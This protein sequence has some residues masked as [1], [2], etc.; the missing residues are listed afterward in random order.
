M[1]FLLIRADALSYFKLTFQ[2]IGTGQGFD[3][4]MNLQACQTA[5]IISADEY[6]IHNAA[7][8]N[9]LGAVRRFVAEEVFRYIESQ[10]EINGAAMG[11]IEVLFTTSHNDGYNQNREKPVPLGTASE[12]YSRTNHENQLNTIINTMPFDHINTGTDPDPHVPD[13]QIWVD[14]GLPFECHHL[15]QS[16]PSWG[17]D[18]YSLILHEA[19]HALGFSSLFLETGF[20]GLA[21]NN[22]VNGPYGPYSTF[23]IFLRDGDNLPLIINGTFTGNFSPFITDSITFALPNFPGRPP[24]PIFSP[25]PTFINGS[26]LCHLDLRRSNYMQP[27]VMAPQISEG[28]S[29]RKWTLDELYI[30]C[31][32]GYTL[33]SNVALQK[34]G[35]APGP[36]GINDA[37]NYTINNT[38]REQCFD[39]VANDLPTGNIE[40]SL[41]YGTNGLLNHAPYKCT[42]RVESGNQRI[43][44][45]YKPNWCGQALIQYQP[46]D[47]L[48]RRPGNVVRV[49]INGPNCNFCPDD[50]CNLVCNGDFE[51]AVPM[52]IYEELPIRK[53]LDFPFPEPSRV[54]FWWGNHDELFMRGSKKA[55]GFKDLDN[56]HNP[57]AWNSPSVINN[58]YVGMYSQN[59]SSSVGENIYTRTVIPIQVNT[60]YRL[61]FQA[62]P[63]DSTIIDVFVS[64]APPGT[65]NVT[66]FLVQS[67][68]LMNP[69]EINAWNLLSTNT[70]RIT[71]PPATTLPWQFLIFQAR[72]QTAPYIYI[73]DIRLENVDFG[74]TLSKTAD[75]TTANPGDIVTFTIT[76]TNTGNR[77]VR[78]VI[79]SDLVDPSVF[80]IINIFHTGTLN[81]VNPHVVEYS[82][83]PTTGQFSIRT[84]IITAEV[85]PLASCRT[86]SNCAQITQ[87]RGRFAS[88]GAWIDILPFSCPKTSDCR[89]I[90]IGNG[91]GCPCENE[92]ANLGSKDIY[93]CEEP[94]GTLQL[95]PPS[96]FTSPYTNGI[97]SYIWVDP[98]NVSTPSNNL[99]LPSP[100]I[101][102]TYTLKILSTGGIGPNCQVAFKNYNV[103]II[104]NIDPSIVN[105]NLGCEGYSLNSLPL[106]SDLTNGNIIVWHDIN[107]NVITDP[108]Y[109]LQNF[110]QITGSIMDSQGCVLQSVVYNIRIDCCIIDANF[111]SFSKLIG[112]DDLGD[113]TTTTSIL[114][115]DGGTLHCASGIYYAHFI[116][117]N[118]Q[119]NLEWEKRYDENY[120]EEEIRIRVIKLAEHNGEYYFIGNFLAGDRNRNH[121]DFGA[122]IGKLDNSGNIQWVTGIKSVEGRS[123]VLHTNVLGQIDGLMVLG[124]HNRGNGPE[125]CLFKCNFSGTVSWRRYLRTNTLPGMSSQINT[126]NPARDIVEIFTNQGAAD[127][128]IVVGEY[129]QSVPQGNTPVRGMVVTKFDNGGNYVSHKIFE[130]EEIPKKI[131]QTQGTNPGDR[132]VLIVGSFGDNLLNEYPGR[133][134]FL[135][136]LDINLNPLWSNNYALVGTSQNLY[137]GLEVIEQRE[138][139]TN[140]LI[141]YLMLCRN[142]INALTLVNTNVDGTVKSNGINRDY[143]FFGASIALNGFLHQYAPV[144]SFGNLGITSEGGYYLAA[145]IHKNGPRGIIVIKTNNRGTASCQLPLKIK[146]IPYTTN[147]YLAG[148]IQ[149]VPTYDAVNR[150]WDPMTSDPIFGYCCKKDL[151]YT[152][153]TICENMNVNPGF[154]F[155][156]CY[157]NT[158]F[159]TNAHIPGAVFEWNFGDGTPNSFVENPNHQYNLNGGYT[160]TVC[161]TVTYLGCTDTK[162]QT[163]TID[164]DESSYIEE[165]CP[166]DGV[167]WFWVDA[168]KYDPNNSYDHYIIH[169]ENGIEADFNSQISGHQNIQRSTGDYTIRYYDPN[170]CLKKILHLRIQPKVPSQTTCFKTVYQCLFVLD[171][172]GIMPDC[173]DC[174]PSINVGDNIELFPVQFLSSIN[175]VSKY[176]RRIIN[177]T[178]CRECIFT[179]DIVRESCNFEP[180]FTWYP[181]PP[182]KWIL[183][184][185]T[186]TGPQTQP[187]NN[188]VSWIVKD[189]TSMMQIPMPFGQLV[190]F[191]GIVGHTYEICMT[192]TYCA[193][194]GAP[195]FKTICYTF[196]LGE[197]LP[198]LGG[199]ENNT[200]DGIAKENQLKDKDS[201]TLSVSNLVKSKF[202]LSIKPNPSSDKFTI[203]NHYQVNQYN[204]VVIYTVDGQEILSFENTPSGF[205]Y[206]LSDYA[207]GVY[208]IKVTVGTETKILKLVL[209]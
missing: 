137:Y 150:T 170:G 70:F 188:Q 144:T 10:M 63:E 155:N 191:P 35:C 48:T 55:D 15:E 47:Q 154:T 156:Q 100:V 96:N 203:F 140:T 54:D 152:P 201:G 167:S 28:T 171:L 134:V 138:N 57:N 174:N 73:D 146:N 126:A 58:N 29:K 33:K 106:N 8:R 187:C 18:L 66:P 194:D 153:T 20:S 7:G 147:E 118:Q 190:E 143:Q 178:Q 50:P 206:D 200:N 184:N 122:R 21:D 59:P 199:G 39:V 51:D 83:I 12:F 6:A 169:D 82:T 90:K 92:L 72:G 32:I 41:D 114:T 209:Q 113:F 95:T 30:L 198:P 181:M 5:G 163:I 192:V 53:D 149:D 196:E 71:N 93:T 157:P 22:K 205:E 105:L 111:N 129:I 52:E 64:T 120:N 97:L 175:G 62:F 74:Y 208:F 38:D 124:S 115:S 40:V 99:T 109:E 160:Y 81:S 141:G 102:G 204:K 131:I 42:A 27:Y 207:S 185:T 151:F 101:P 1:C 148:I 78:D 142:S 56:I 139:Q 80:N 127:G 69:S 77:E 119:G 121:P 179:F 123:F 44:V 183:Q 60:N 145:Q 34:Y 76:L 75:R 86:I 31:Q 116:K 94:P 165:Y 37:F 104:E 61:S 11:N 112:N 133:N 45:T 189:L 110:D 117:L 4:T 168:N 49:V 88:P 23:D 17:F 176:S 182:N 16:T 46:I 125:I 25:S 186:T 103:F 135:K 132:A 128:F 136:K 193:C 3:A 130:G 14:F 67:Y 85:L 84:I 202:E 2:D 98:N 91:S 197:A 180:S 79:I 13:M 43:C 195:C 177:W 166:L 107:G 9:N 24:L 172:E 19:T 164:F 173:E 89:D 87:M 108:N 159:N 65:V 161:L 26:S 162:C 68:N 36:V 158:S